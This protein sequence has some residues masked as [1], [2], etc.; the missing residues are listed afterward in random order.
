MW[1]DAVTT[2]KYNY[3]VYTDRSETAEVDELISSWTENISLI[4]FADTLWC[5]VHRYTGR[6]TNASV[7]TVIYSFASDLTWD[8][9]C[10]RLQIIFTYLLSYLLFVD[11]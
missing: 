5:V 7:F 10:A 3:S 1:H 2:V 11:L 8:N 9:P 6:N 4:L